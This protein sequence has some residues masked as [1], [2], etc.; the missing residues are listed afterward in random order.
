MIY[1][2]WIF[3]LSI[4]AGFAWYASGKKTLAAI[5][6]VAI[7]F[8]LLYVIETTQGRAVECIETPQKQHVLG[9]KLNEPKDEIHLLIDGSPPTFCHMPYSEKVAEGLQKSTKG[10]N[11]QPGKLF[12]REGQDGK[13][14]ADV[15][16]PTEVYVK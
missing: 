13:Q 2:T 3:L 1:A 14:F 8:P 12:I 9:Y 16:F 4:M 11:G 7:S 15:E 6:F 5:L 10:K